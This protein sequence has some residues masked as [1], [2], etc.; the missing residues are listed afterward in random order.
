VTPQDRVDA[1]VPGGI[2]HIFQTGAGFQQL[3]DDLRMISSRVR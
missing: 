3:L 2:F 1:L